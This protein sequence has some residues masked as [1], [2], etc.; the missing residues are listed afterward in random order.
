VEVGLPVV[1][2]NIPGR[3]GIT[4]TPTTIAHIYNECTN[5]VAIKDATGS[6]DMVCVAC[7]T[8]RVLFGFFCTQHG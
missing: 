6:L 3:T 4:M 2:Y 8:P 5:V 1:L 7:S